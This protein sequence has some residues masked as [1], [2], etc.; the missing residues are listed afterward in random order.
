MSKIIVLDFSYTKNLLI[1]VQAANHFD[2]AELISPETI[3]ARWNQEKP[4]LSL[5][6]DL[7]CR[8]IVNEATEP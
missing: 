5:R 2:G 3:T 7:A 6:L 1:F 4:C 8:P